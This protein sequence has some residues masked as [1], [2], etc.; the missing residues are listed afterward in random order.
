MVRLALF[1]SLP[2]SPSEVRMFAFT[3]WQ[4]R[5]SGS[6]P[7]SASQNSSKVIGGISRLWVRSCKVSPSLDQDGFPDASC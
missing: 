2:E 3:L 6:T 1:P 7:T 4:L 5:I